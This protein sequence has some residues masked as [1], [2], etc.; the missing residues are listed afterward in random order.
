MIHWHTPVRGSG[1]SHNGAAGLNWQSKN[2]SD[3][4]ERGRDVEA[5][6][7]PEEPHRPSM[8]SFSC[9]VAADRGGPCPGGGGQCRRNRVRNSIT[10]TQ[11]RINRAAAACAQRHDS[12]AHAQQGSRM[13]AATGRP[14]PRRPQPDPPVSEGVTQPEGQ[15][16]GIKQSGEQSASSRIRR[17]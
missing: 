1:G 3:A 9:S 11:V 13:A 5:M 6:N 4:A 14:Q 7:I 10:V 16:R 2:S 15:E 8:L 17:G 12:A